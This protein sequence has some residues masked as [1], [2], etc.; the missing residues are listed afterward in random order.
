M[1]A[2][3][4][5]HADSAGGA[6]APWPERRD[7]QREV[8]LLGTSHLAQTPEDTA[9][10]YATD[11]GDVLGPKRQRELETLTDRLAAWDPDRIAVEV[12][13]TEQ[14]VLDGAFAAYADGERP[15]DA[16]EGWER[17]ERDEVIQ[18]GF[19]LARKLGHD[20]VAAVDYRQSPMALLTEE[21]R[22]EL[23]DS[24]RALNVD[25][26]GVA[27]P[28][29]DFEEQIGAEQQ[30]LDD[31]TLLSHYTRLN[32]LRPDGHAWANDKQFYAAAFERSAPGDYTALKVLTAWMQRNL[33]IASHIWTV[34]DA[35]DER[36]LVVFGAS[37]IPQLKQMLAS[38][39]MTT[40]VSP[41]PYLTE[42][43]T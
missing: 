35:D 16:V 20:S 10:A 14:A 28:L 40:P 21:E 36:V 7:G 41:L 27:Y 13:A 6:G 1:T 17:D 12:P 8:M 4:G 15:T 9:N 39:P 34:P 42:E 38:A 32:T 18:V 33:R 31:G 2:E 25:P 37:H 43:S 22:R 23:P 11:A 5:G 19:R 3:R 30:R 29:P 24:L 26:D